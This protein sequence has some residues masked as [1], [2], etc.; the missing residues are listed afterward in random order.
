MLSPAFQFYVQD[1]LTGTLYMSAEEIGAY[2]LLLCYQWD[3]GA[4]PDSDRDL[5]R[6]SR[7]KAK[8]LV[9]VR[10]KFARCEDGMLR[11]IRMEMEREKQ[12][13]YRELKSKAGIEGNKKRWTKSSQSDTAAI[14]EESQTVALQSSSSTSFS[15]SKIN[16]VNK[17]TRVG[18]QLFEKSPGAMM[19]ER[20]EQGIDELMLGPYRTLRLEDVLAEIEQ[21]CPSGTIF[22]N[23]QH[24]LNK[25]KSVATKMLKAPKDK[26]P[27]NRTHDYSQYK[28][29]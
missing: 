17:K 2:M 6:I 13:A 8:T 22:T 23:D 9:V 21:Q 27:R 26:P 3:K 1:F 28:R 14:A 20:Y 15:T 24:L 10:E 25:F 7:S 19:M 11:N 12:A 29:Q 16:Y 5:L 4:L 18:N